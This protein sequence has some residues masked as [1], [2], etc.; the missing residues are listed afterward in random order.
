MKCWKVTPQILLI[1]Y[2]RLDPIS[3]TLHTIWNSESNKNKKL[4]FCRDDC[5]TYQCFDDITKISTLL[6]SFIEGKH[7]ATWHFYKIH[8]C[9]SVALGTLSNSLR[10]NT[11][12][13]AA[14]LLQYLDIL[15]T[16]KYRKNVNYAVN[17]LSSFNILYSYWQNDQLLRECRLPTKLQ[18]T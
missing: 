11:H 12:V 9:Y 7:C 16:F 14:R 6:N 10:N 5:T 15:Y 2:R 3:Y 17:F 8:H 18:C 4:T 13:G 1:V